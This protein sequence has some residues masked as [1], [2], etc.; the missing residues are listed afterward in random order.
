[1]CWLVSFYKALAFHFCTINLCSL[2][3]SGHFVVWHSLLQKRTL[4]HGH[5]NI[6]ISTLPQFMHFNPRD[7]ALVMG[8]SSMSNFVVPSIVDRF[9]WIIT[10]SAGSI[11][12]TLVQPIIARNYRTCRCFDSSLSS[13]STLP[14]RNGVV[15]FVEPGII[16]CNF[17]QA[18][19]NVPM[20]AFC[21]LALQSITDWFEC[22]IFLSFSFG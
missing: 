8:A 13:K 5:R 7:I 17:K 15:S 12:S 10:E 22:S 3:C 6:F 9:W 14:G 20:I 11:K 21:S 4:W 18:F 2:L 16:T 19:V 1:V